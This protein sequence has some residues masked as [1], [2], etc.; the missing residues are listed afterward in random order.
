MYPLIILTGIIKTFSPYMRKHILETL[1]SHEYFLL[2]LII[3]LFIVLV[4][5]IGEIIY[6][7]IKHTNNTNNTNKPNKTNQPW[8]NHTAIKMYNNCC[9]LTATQKICALVIA[10]I[11]ISS[12]IIMFHFDKHFFTP[13]INST[14]MKIVSTILLVI[15]GIFIF[16]ESYNYTQ[17]FGLCLSIVGGLL[18]IVE[19]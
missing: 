18:L 10:I 13:L 8:N 11:T 5:G 2:N 14:L 19:S 3:I 6:I 16:K 7:G 9:K 12:S 17:I 15:V 1:E 4:L